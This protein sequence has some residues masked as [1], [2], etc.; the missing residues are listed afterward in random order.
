MFPSKVMKDIALQLLQTKQSEHV[1]AVHH[2][3]MCARYIFLSPRRLE[4]YHRKLTLTL[5]IYLSI[6]LIFI[7][8]RALS[9]SFFPW[10][11]KETYHTQNRVNCLIHMQMLPQRASHQIP[12]R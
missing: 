3:A 10:K 6:Y 2:V 4:E 9:L 11:Q 5:S 1:R 7:P 12:N 8:S